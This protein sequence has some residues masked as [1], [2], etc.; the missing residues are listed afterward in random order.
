MA[1]LCTLSERLDIPKS[2]LL[3][4]IEKGELAA[5][6]RGERWCIAEQWAADWMRRQIRKMMEAK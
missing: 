3:E 6:K 5:F 1:T 2:V 4:Q